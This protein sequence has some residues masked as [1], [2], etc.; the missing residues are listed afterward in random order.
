MGATMGIATH[1]I[2]AA[3][4]GAIAA[5]ARGVRQPGPPLPGDRLVR[6]AT[7]TR[8]ISAQMPAPPERVWPW[9]AQMG[10]GRAG[11]YSIDIID[12]G[13]APS[14]REIVPGL[15]GLAPGDRMEASTL[16]GPP[17][18]ATM[19]DE[20]RAL[21][22]T[23]R[24][25]RGWLRVSYTYVLSPAGEGATRLTTRLRMGGRPG[26]VALLLSPMMLASH[27]VGQRVQLSRLRRR[28]SGR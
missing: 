3:A 10:A 12:N 13:G 19:V 23:L 16:G 11:W 8:T 25:K 26:L 5:L 21:V 20:P 17:F 1:A 15:Q 14:A 24:G 7:M 28:V 9:L 4:A 2:A 27:E 22:T 6:R 18:I